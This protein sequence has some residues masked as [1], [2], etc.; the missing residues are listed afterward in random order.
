[1]GAVSSTFRH[2]FFVHCTDLHPFSAARSRIADNSITE[3]ITSQFN[4]R[5]DPLCSFSVDSQVFTIF[6][7]FF[8]LDHTR[9]IYN[10]RKSTP[11][12]SG[13]RGQHWPTAEAGGNDTRN[14][15]EGIR[16]ESR[17][18][19]R[20]V[21]ASEAKQSPACKYCEREDCFVAPLLAMTPI[22]RLLTHFW[23]GRRK[24]DFLELDNHGSSR[25]ISP[26][27]VMCRHEIKTIYPIQSTISRGH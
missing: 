20:S 27:M 7:G 15:S 1:M 6:Q 10:L 21:I 19:S 24:S 18:A 17:T 12:S 22:E 13:D 26:R 16:N 8:H 23:I 3:L 9:A 14:R 2:Q 11:H 4:D 5:S 25:R